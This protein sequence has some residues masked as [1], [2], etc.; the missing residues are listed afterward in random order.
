MLNGTPEFDPEKAFGRIDFARRS[1]AILAVSGGG[2]STALLIAFNRWAGRVHPHLHPVCVTV[3][4]GLRTKSAGEAGQVGELCAY[5][6]IPH[7]IKRWTGEKPDSGLAEAA[8]EARYAL[9]AQAAREAGT[10]IVLTGHNAD[11]QAETVLMRSARGSGRGLAGMAGATLFDGEVWILRPLLMNDR[12]SLRALLRAH[13]ATWI[14]DPTNDE[15]RFERVRVRRTLSGKSDRCRIEEV[16]RLEAGARV[17]IA[18]ASAGL[19]QAHA[20]V[21]SPGLVR[22]DQSLLGADDAR[23]DVWRFLLACCGGR[24]RLPG[25]PDIDR[26]IERLGRRRTCLSGVVVTKRRDAVFLHREL[27]GDRPLN[28]ENGVFDGR[29]RISDESRAAGWRLRPFDPGT[30]NPGQIHSHRIPASLAKAAMAAEPVLGRDIAK[31]SQTSAEK[32][33]IHRYLAPFDRFL[34]DFD[35]TLANA[36]A[37]LFGRDT[38]PPPPVIVQKFR[39]S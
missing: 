12:E 9:L 24:S 20:S 17:D 21:V 7:K 39:E 26:L 35:L 37:N 13:G 8:R 10:D 34:P 30:D 15:R 4:H 36:V 28:D 1:S 3:D 19:V 6:E 22:L 18:Q 38:Y 32:P 14:E 5:L 11:D 27:R 29:Y 31:Q 2:D 25:R 33:E 23:A 16:A